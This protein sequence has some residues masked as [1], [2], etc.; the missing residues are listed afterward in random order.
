LIV[1]YA[2]F[3]KRE[4]LHVSYKAMSRGAKISHL[5]EDVMK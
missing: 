4:L 1:R 3:D 5:V 2:I